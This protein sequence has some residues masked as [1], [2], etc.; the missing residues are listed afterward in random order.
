MTSK[1]SEYVMLNLRGGSSYCFEALTHLECACI[2]AFFFF[3]F[4]LGNAGGLDLKTLSVFRDML[5]KPQSFFIT[6]FKL[7]HSSLCAFLDLNSILFS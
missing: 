4:F 2:N 5:D 6:L 3:P 7:V 1:L